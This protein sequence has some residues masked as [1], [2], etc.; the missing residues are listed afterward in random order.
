MTGQ[1]LPLAELPAVLARA[2]LGVVPNRDTRA[3]RLMLPE[4]LLEYAMLGVPVVAAR[5]PTIE[6]YFRDSI[7]YFSPGQS[8]ELAKAIVRLRRDES[9]RRELKERAAGVLYQLEAEQKARSYMSI[10]N[11][12]VNN[13][14][15]GISGAAA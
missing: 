11:E 2:S 7:A 9:L 15:D 10:V 8:H 13:C 4:K 14:G 3:T 5:L 12:L 6:Y 1:W